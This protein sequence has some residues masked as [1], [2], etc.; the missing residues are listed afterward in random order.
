MDDT[1]HCPICGN[2]LRTVRKNNSYL[3]QIDKTF[4]YL[5]RSCIGVNHALQLFTDV[6]TD[7]VDLLRISL[8]PKYSKYVELDFVHQ[9]SRISL[10]KDGQI[11][12]VNI[13]KM[14]EPDF[15]L[16]TKLKEKVNMYV[17]FS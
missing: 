11:N 7:R 5:E 4:S 3:H 8:N 1:L 16:L 12:Y 17:T 13:D 10:L 6:A 2:K 15:P 14:V 9:A